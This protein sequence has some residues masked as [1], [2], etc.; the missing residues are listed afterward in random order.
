MENAKSVFQIL[1][2]RTILGGNG[3]KGF[4]KTSKII[5]S[6]ELNSRKR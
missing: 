3:Q 6:F 5:W 2:K 1:V 4:V